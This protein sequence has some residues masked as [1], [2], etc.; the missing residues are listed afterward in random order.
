MHINQN[1]N[2]DGIKCHLFY[3][4]FYFVLLYYA[5]IIIIVKKNLKILWANYSF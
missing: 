5:H 3:L 2:Y 4:L 1:I